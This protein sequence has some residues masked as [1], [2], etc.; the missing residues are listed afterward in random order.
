[1]DHPSDDHSQDPW[2]VRPRSGI[3][4]LQ[5]GMTRAE[6]A[7]QAG[8]LGPITYENDLGAGPGDL[9]ALLQSFG[10]LISEEDVAATRAAMAEA[11]QLQQGMVL[12]HRRCGLVLTFQDGRLAEIMA[13]CDGPPIHLDGIA[14]FAAPRIE[15]VAA[16]S[17][18]LGD[19][20]YCD[21]E[22]VAFQNAPLWLHGFMLG[23]PGFA[24]HPDR[25]SAKE[26]SIALRAP[27]MRGVAEVEWE[28]FRPLPLPA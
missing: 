7:A 1:M 15:A 14:L 12:E 2:A 26:V 21:G 4:G 5:L 22:H 25:E 9:A 27:G 17:R 6:V 10:D 18:A 28:R 16:L 23:A 8:P 24:P 13:P 11:A 20:P 19:P 3:G